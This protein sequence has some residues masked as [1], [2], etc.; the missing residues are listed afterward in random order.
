MTVKI[1]ILI[2][3]N[4]FAL[5]LLSAGQPDSLNTENQNSRK[6]YDLEGLTIRALA[7]TGTLGYSYKKEITTDNLGSAVNIKDLLTDIPG[8]RIT[9][10]GKG[11]TDLRIRSFQRK[12]IKI[13][14]DGVPVSGGYF[15]NVDLNAFPIADIREINVVKGPVSPLYG[16]NTLGGV[17]NIITNDNDPG[18]THQARFRLDRSKTYS[19]SYTGGKGSRFSNFRYYFDRSYSPGYYMSD[20]FAA[21]PYEDGGLR[22]NTSF[23]RYSVGVGWNG[24]IHSIHHLDF[25]TG[26][27]YLDNKDIPAPTYQA[28]YRKFVDWHSY[29][30]SLRYSIPLRYNLKLESLIYTDFLKDVYEEYVDAGMTN[31]ILTSDLRNTVIGFD[32]RSEWIVND[33]MISR[34]GYNYEFNTYKRRDDSFYTDW[35]SGSTVQQQLW[36]QPEYNITRN[37]TFTAGASIS[38]LHIDETEVNFAGSSGMYLNVPNN[39]RFS[40]SYSRSIRNPILRELY[41]YSQGNPGL[42]P[43][44]ADKYEITVASPYKIGQRYGYLHFALFYNSIFDLIES[45]M[46][47]EEN[48]Q[49][50]ENIARA[51]SYGTDLDLAFKPF[52]RWESNLSYTLLFPG[53]KSDYSMLRIPR[54]N[55]ILANRFNFTENLSFRLSSEYCDRRDDLDNF[56]NPQYIPAYF[57]HDLGFTYKYRKFAFAS[58]IDNVFD[59]LYY[60]K[61]GF[62]GR[63]RN[64]YFSLELRL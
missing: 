30:T 23:S 27:T 33:M 52:S 55:V 10:G 40:L 31:P 41:S 14:F 46:V 11:E 15:G 47:P 9:T 44:K 59:T 25:R 60:E 28:S 45:I 7:T 4:I 1:I 24:D 48:L 34:Q 37:L 19:I 6:V 38:T 61:Y 54:N 20:S 63:G 18:W 39:M 57:S 21:T 58:G 50:Y 53:N 64:F 16:T 8:L 13:M 43:E 26:Y 51:D 35:Y 42:L 22:D 32:T 62:P 2:V 29:N 49:R 5:S 3:I 56:N 17:I 36:L 12:Q